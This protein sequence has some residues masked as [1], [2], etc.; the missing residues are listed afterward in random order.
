[1]QEKVAVLKYC[2]LVHE[3][4]LQSADHLAIV[5]LLVVSNA[6]SFGG[7]ST[8]PEFDNES[9]SSQLYHLQDCLQI[10]SNEVHLELCSA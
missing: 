8:E 1:M 7:K 4:S 3:N 2:I 5:G 9:D 6:Q 10:A